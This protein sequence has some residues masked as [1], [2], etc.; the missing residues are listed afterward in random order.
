MAQ[1]G[2]RPEQMNGR[3]NGDFVS[4]TAEGTPENNTKQT[5]ERARAAMGDGARFL[6]TAAAT[7]VVLFGLREAR[8][9]IVPVMMAVFLAII[10]YSITGILRRY[11]R[12]PHWLAVTFTVLVDFGVIFCVVSLIKF[13]AAD[14]KST[15]Q[16][17]IVMRFEEKF[18]TFMQLMD[19][20]GMGESARAMV[21][22]PQD[23]LGTSQL[24]AISQTITSQI[25]SFMSVTTLVLILMTFLLGEAP[26]FLRNFHRLPNSIQGK[27]QVLAALRGIQ[28]Y[29]FIKTVASLCTGLLAWWLC[30]AMDIPFAFLWGVVA[31][32]LNYIPTIGSIVAAIPPILLGLL[33]GDWGTALFVTGGYIAINFAIGNGIEPLF[34]GKQFGIATSVVLLSVLLWGWVWGPCGMLLA[35]PITVLTKLALENSRDLNWLALIIDDEGKSNS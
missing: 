10:S 35:V 9:L 31:Y 29:L 15:L 6:L 13:L 8:D 7:I 14:M 16:G 18:N 12:F 4:D 1:Q 34:L 17:D 27:G 11:L 22:S 28:R 19:R 30:A 2:N 23:I 24:L 20:W 25:L 33:L 32:V 26:L 5:G 21:E 3:I